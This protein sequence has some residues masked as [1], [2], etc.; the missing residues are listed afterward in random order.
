MGCGLSLGRLV[1]FVTL[2]GLLCGCL[3]VLSWV[4]GFF[5]LGLLVVA[6]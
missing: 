4:L 6:G 1:F 5:L 3:V 2:F